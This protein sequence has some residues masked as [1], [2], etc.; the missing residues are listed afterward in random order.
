MNILH[1]NTHLDLGGISSYLETLGKALIKKGHRVS[2]LSGGGSKIPAFE[3]NGIRCF[4][5][6]IRTKSEI[7]PKLFWAMPAVV[8]MV[9]NVK[10]DIL[11]AHTRV[12]EVLACVVSRMTDIP[13][14]STAHGFYKS[15]FG[16]KLFPCWG[17]RVIA[18]SSLVAEELQKTHGVLPAKIRVVNNAIDME[19]LEKRLRAQNPAAVRAEHRIPEK[20]FVIGCIARLVR[21]KGQEYL[22]QALSRLT[23]EI[24]NSYLL[25]VGNGPEKERLEALVAE[26]GLGSRVCMIPGVEDTTAVLSALDVFVHPATYREGFGLAIAEALAARKPVILTKIPALDTLFR[27]GEDALLVPPKDTEALTRAILELARDAE[28]SGALA[29]KGYEKVSMLCRAER[30]ADEMDNIYQEVLREHGQGKKA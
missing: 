7:H 2:I 27:N 24:P 13:F 11:H 22:V 17:E 19:G 10:F 16:R 3:R 20:A 4:S 28:R 8:R 9:R 30:Q 21:D 6:P 14:V 15:R 5:L 25:L 29:D 1:L 12:S 18:V 26:L 23:K